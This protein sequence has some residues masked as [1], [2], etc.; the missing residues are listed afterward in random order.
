[1]YRL[2]SWRTRVREVEMDMAFPDELDTPKDV[3]ARQRFQRYRGMRSFRTS[4]WDPYENLPKDYAK[5]F[6]FEDYRRTERAVRR[7]AE[8]EMD[9]S[10]DVSPES[11]RSRPHIH[12]PPTARNTRDAPLEARAR[13]RSAEPG[14]PESVRAVRLVAARAQG[15]RPELYRTAE[16]R[17][18]RARKVKGAVYIIS[19]GVL[20]ESERGCA[21]GRT[22]WFSVWARGA[23]ALAR[24][25]ASTRAAAARAPTT[26]T[27][28]SGSC[29]PAW[30]ASPR[31]TA[32]S[33]LARSRASC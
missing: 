21:P 20:V 18:H 17:V 4:P 33:S 8:E 25:S 31:R 30:P 19:L 16:H 29:A 23:F 9:T 14:P 26:C 32:P 24:S 22:R 3:P 5:I 1:M 13:K 11:R 28:L 27:S 7:R 12:P 15:F 6:Q 2:A 10:V